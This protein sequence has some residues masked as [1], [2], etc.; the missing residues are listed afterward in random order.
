MQQNSSS[1][2]ICNINIAVRDIILYFKHLMCDAQQ[3]KAKL[4]GFD[5]LHDETCFDWR[6]LVRG[7][8]PMKFRERQRDHFGKK[9]CFYM[10][11]CFFLK[12]SMWSSYD[13]NITCSTKTTKNGW[14]KNSK[15]LCKIW[16]F[17]VFQTIATSTVTTL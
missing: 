11:E 14:T 10:L 3:K 5:Q 2:T 8:C 1:D 6:L 17:Q 16:Q 7:Y 12:K 9:G 4:F 13:W 15:F